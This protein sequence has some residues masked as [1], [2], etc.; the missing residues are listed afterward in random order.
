M[1][2]RPKKLV[3]YNNIP[4]ELNEGG[5][6]R[7]TELEAPKLSKKKSIVGR[8]GIV[9]QSRAEAM[10]ANWL[11][12]SGIEY[13]P[14]P[15][16]DL[17]GKVRNRRGDF[18]LIRS[19]EMVEVFMGSVDGL[20]K[21]GDDIPAWGNDYLKV[22][23]EK[24]AYFRE[25]DQKLIVI[26]AEIYR[27]QGLNPYLN[28][29]HQIFADYGIYLDE[30]VRKELPINGDARG[31]LW[32]LEEFI[33]YALKNRFT[34]LVDFQSSGHSDLYAVLNTRP[35]LSNQLRRALDEIHNRKSAVRKEELLPLE[36]LRVIVM[37]MGIVERAEYEESYR[38]NQLPSNAPVSVPQSYDITWH[39]FIHGKHIK[40]FS[41][42]WE[43]REIVRRKRFQSRSLFFDA[44]RTDPDL[45][46]VRKSPSSAQG[47]YPEFISW[48][49]FLG[50]LS[51]SEQ[52]DKKEK[53]KEL[54]N[55]ENKLAQLNFKDAAHCLLELKLTS[56][57]KI[58]AQSPAFYKR[59]Q[60]RSDWPQLLYFLSGRV[61]L[62]NSKKEA[63]KILISEQC[64]DRADF[65][66]RRASNV[67]LQRIP[68]HIERVGLGIFEAVRSCVDGDDRNH[69]N[70]LEAFWRR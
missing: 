18:R 60:D 62:V 8:D 15:K 30:S 38:L 34:M 3:N 40:Q 69:Q 17:K 28:H 47:G 67:H 57:E 56:A 48:P 6:L 55:L 24:E 61:A 12:F 9:Y 7:I 68:K 31:M 43:A 33:E 39:E 45:L 51:D 36:D 70:V 14:H 49:D 53:Q 59:L 29:I 52:K 22:R 44:V 1:P 21:R 4:D 41:P 20:A 32:M 26:E 64:F 5:C 35:E 54:L 13:Q 16:L 65:F 66:A 58:Q 10:V 23:G 50:T 27:Y 63:I 42:F 11:Y 19:G 2:K 25:S 46:F 37:G